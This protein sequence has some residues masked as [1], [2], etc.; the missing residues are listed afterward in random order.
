MRATGDGC[1]SGGLDWRVSRLLLANTGWSFLSELSLLRQVALPAVLGEDE[2]PVL[3]DCGLR[4]AGDRLPMGVE[5]D[6]E[7]SSLVLPLE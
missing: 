5:A 2:A 3:T 1:W 6:M 4:C 7:P